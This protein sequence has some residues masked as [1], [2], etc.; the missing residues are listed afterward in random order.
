MRIRRI[1][2]T[3]IIEN[4]PKKYR[5]LFERLYYYYF[6]KKS[7]LKTDLQIIKQLCNPAKV[8]LDIG[9]NDGTIT[10]YLCKFTPH[11]YCFEPVPRMVDHLK[12]KFND[13]NVTIENC[14]LGNA[15]ENLSLSI[16][17][18]GSKRYETRSSLIKNFEND[19]IL[20]EKVTDVEKIRV[21]VKRLDDFNINNIGF[22]KIDVEGFEFDVLKGIENTIRREM[23]NIYIE[24]EQRH[25][26]KDSI[27]NIFQYI[28]KLGYFAYFVDCN[29]NS[30]KIRSIEMFDVEK[31]QKESNEKTDY[32]INNF[33][34]SPS[35]IRNMKL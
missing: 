30:K 11:V 35:P 22:M 13:C 7:N 24:I 6:D 26:E 8:S 12:R 3:N 5:F 2:R 31:M 23:Q 4:L 25:H 28:K 27:Y 19:F 17:R 34:F 21:A 1:I 10:M 15:N 18:V 32:Y 33:I 20:G 14:A 9:A 29:N 16:P